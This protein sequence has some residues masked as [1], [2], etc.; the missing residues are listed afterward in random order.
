MATALKQNIAAK[1]ND[2]TDIYSTYYPVVYS[3]VYTKV[4]NEDDTNDICQEVFLR[5]FR[6][7][8]EV[9]N[10][11][12]WLFIALRYVVIEYYRKKRPEA[13]VDD[14]FSD[15]ALTFVNGFRDAR[16]IIAE[17]IDDM[18][19]FQDDREKALFDLI[20]V[21]NFSYEE[22]GKQLGMTKRQVDYRYNQITARIL[23]SLRRRGVKHI[24]DLL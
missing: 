19:N 16:I 17:A 5:L 4:G 22:A 2:F 13:N 8:D 10:V 9:D 1:K 6:K 20:A 3:A 23:E 11:R 7:F 24:E 15:V 21:N 14:L 12:K 18:N